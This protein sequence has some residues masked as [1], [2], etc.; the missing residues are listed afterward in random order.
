MLFL[1]QTARVTI[2]SQPIC[3]FL[4]LLFFSLFLCFLFFLHSCCSWA[5]RRGQWGSPANVTIMSQTA[6][7]IIVTLIFASH[8]QRKPNK[9]DNYVPTIFFFVFVALMEP[10]S[11]QGIQRDRKGC[12]RHAKGIEKCPQGIQKR[13]EKDSDGAQWWPRHPKGIE[14]GCPKDQKGCTR[15]PKWSESLAL[16]YWVAAPPP[17]SHARQF[18]FARAK[19]LTP[20]PKKQRS[21]CKPIKN[22]L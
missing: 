8:L 21:L 1:S 4:C 12:T 15:H 22:S 11:A 13:S 10:K 7:D 18:H 3:F 2:L 17:P 19:L 20:T 14:K 16:A 6:R 5:R 9:C